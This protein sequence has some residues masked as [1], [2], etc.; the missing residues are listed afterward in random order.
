MIDEDLNKVE[1]PFTN[2]YKNYLKYQ[3]RAKDFEQ[4]QTKKI[5]ESSNMSKEQKY[6]EVMNRAHLLEHKANIKQ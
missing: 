5:L 4:D 3:P 2:R 1:K 6:I